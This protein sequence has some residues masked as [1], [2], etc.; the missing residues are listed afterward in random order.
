MKIQLLFQSL[1]ESVHDTVYITNISDDNTGLSNGYCIWLN[2]TMMHLV[3]RNSTSRHDIKWDMVTNT[4]VYN[5]LA[6]E[7]DFLNEA[8]R[9]LQNVSKDLMAGRAHIYKNS[10][11]AAA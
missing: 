10:V 3:L 1:L 5:D 11:E 7:P 6:Q 9:I 2:S 4:L 8:L